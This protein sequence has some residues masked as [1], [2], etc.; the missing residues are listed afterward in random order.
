MPRLAAAT[1]ACVLLVLSL[2]AGA[3]A[4]FSGENGR[5]FYVVGA[6]TTSSTILSA[7]PATGGFVKNVVP[8]ASW[9]APSPDGT[10]IA[11]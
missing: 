1:T 4:T 8:L 6:F 5:V 10:R 3:S 7:C 9:P 11:G 2:A